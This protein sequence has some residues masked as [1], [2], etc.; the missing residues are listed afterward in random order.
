MEAKMIKIKK[1]ALFWL[2]SVVVS[3]F[4]LISSGLAAKF[5]RDYQNIPKDHLVGNKASSVNALKER[6]LPFSFFVVGD[7]QGRDVIETMMKSVLK[8]KNNSFMVIT[9]D[10]VRRPDLWD[11]QFF[12]TEMA[13]EIRP[14]FPV[15]LVPGNHDI[16]YLSTKGGVTPEIYES[17]Y[18]PRNFDFIFNNCLF[19]IYGID[20]NNLRGYLDYLHKTLSEKGKGRKHIFVFEH[21]PPK[22]VGKADSHM[23]P[24]EEE[25]FSLLESYKVTSCFFGDY[26]GYWR[27]Q[28]RG[29]NLI[30]S[31]GGGGRLKD[32]KSP[33][34]VF[35]HMLKITVDENIISEEMMIHPWKFGS[36]TGVLRP[37][38]LVHLFPLVGHR[39]WILYV[40]LFLF[41]SWTIYSGI[42]FFSSLKKGD[43][44]SS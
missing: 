2:L 19:I 43:S 33:W 5:Y 23:L 14:P 22:G 31:G 25:F 32:S 39:V 9:G 3:L 28:R 10:F 40:G 15:F 7:T 44:R 8:E 30:V 12:L 35:H 41:L 29:T 21:H 42:M 24:N 20:Q 17:L 38:V 4:L 1:R 6:G 13:V 16:D 26:H 34:G 18:G 37:W 36:F 27:G 11:H